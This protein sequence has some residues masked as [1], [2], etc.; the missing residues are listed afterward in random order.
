MRE[1]SGI[2]FQTRKSDGIWQHGILQSIY[3]GIFLPVASVASLCK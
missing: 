1:F 2:I 3:L